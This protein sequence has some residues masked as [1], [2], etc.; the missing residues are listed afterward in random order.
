MRQRSDYPTFSD[1]E[2]ERRL[3]EHQVR[4]DD[5]GYGSIIRSTRV[6]KFDYLFGRYRPMR[7][8]SCWW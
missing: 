1:A 8:A 3:L 6:R 5:T 2:L 7:C 4:D